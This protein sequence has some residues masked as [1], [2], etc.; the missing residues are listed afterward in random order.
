[1]G[2]TEPILRTFLV[3]A[4]IEHRL[5]RV[6]TG[7]ASLSEPTCQANLGLAGCDRIAAIDHAGFTAENGVARI[8][9]SHR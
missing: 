7:G 5:P 4:A 2:S 8:S 3:D 1:M 6:Y 9:C